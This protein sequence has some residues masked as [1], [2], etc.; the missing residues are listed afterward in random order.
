MIRSLV[1]LFRRWAAGGKDRPVDKHVD[2]FVYELP[3]QSGQ[4]IRIMQGYGGAYSHTGES[5]FSIDFG[6]PEN[7]PVCAARAGVVYH[8]IDHFTDSGTHPSFKPKANAIYVLHSDDTIAA[9]VHL[10]YR[11]ACVRAG[12]FVRAGEHIGFSGNTGWS[13]SPH[14]HFHV[15]DAIHH[16]RIPTWFN[17][18]EK[19]VTM[20]DFNSVYSRLTSGR[21]D[22]SQKKRTHAAIRPEN[23]SQERDSTSY[24]PELLNLRENV[25]SELSLAGYDILSDYSSI[26]VMH[27]V[28]GFEVCGIVDSDIALHITRLL[29][30]RFPGWNAG[31]IH[32]PDRTE[33]QEWVARIQRDYDLVPEYWE[34]D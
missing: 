3:F 25:A 8:V 7:T 6:M 1:K 22:K 23:V 27:D 16:R 5:H 33:T 28:H 17:T 20:V 26:D 31:W 2:H 13:D 10:V 19:G 12:D 18:I 15:A 24:F 29:L 9:Y 21:D 11:G 32:P 30:S 34:T 14:L 4:R